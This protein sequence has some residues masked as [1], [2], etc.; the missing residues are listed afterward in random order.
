MLHNN[1]YSDAG[2]KLQIVLLTLAPAFLTAGI[3]F[4]LKHL[5]ITFGESFSRIRPQH[6]TYIFISCDIFSI[7][8][9]GA[10]GGIASAAS[11]TQKSLLDA[12]NDLMIT[13]LAFQVFTLLLFGCLAAEYFARVWKHKHELNPATFELRRSMRFRLFLGAL[14]L[15]YLTILIRCVYRVAELAGGWGNSIMQDQA[16]FTGLDSL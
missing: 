8:L 3:Y 2:F 14:S 13:G 7:L 9:Q 5:V 11:D 15:A 6:Y 4:T 1:P 10:G 12:G 16:L